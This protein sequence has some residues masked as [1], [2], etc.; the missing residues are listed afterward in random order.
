MD[1]PF[2]FGE[3][4]RHGG[5][6]DSS[7]LSDPYDQESTIVQVP[8][9]TA[10][11]LL[12]EGAGSPTFGSGTWYQVEILDGDQSTPPEVGWLPR[13]AII[14]LEES[15][16]AGSSCQFQPQ[17]E[18]QSIWQDH[19]QLGCPLR[20]EPDRGF[21]GEQPF[22]HGDMYQ[23]QLANLFVIRVDDEAKSWDSISGDELQ[24]SGALNEDCRPNPPPP[25][26]K[27][28]PMHG[29]GAIW[30]SRPDLQDA[31][32]FATTPERNGNG[33]AIQEF[34][35]GLI[36]HDSEGATYVFLAEEE[37]YVQVQ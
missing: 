30:C 9:E 7:L 29:F 33:D 6:D 27:L 21:F 12:A 11:R 8:A 19:Q 1:P 22:E 14:P 4:I 32:G 18:F 23:A 37:T 16:V 15:Q 36:L 20:A 13:E 17:G 10:V 26:D 34:T 24:Q 25:P 31:L 5:A 28:V 2:P 35:N 3:V